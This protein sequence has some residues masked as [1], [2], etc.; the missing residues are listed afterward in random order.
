M[1]V[2][3]GCIYENTTVSSFFCEVREAKDYLINSLNLIFLSN[4]WYCHLKK[5]IRNGLIL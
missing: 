1:E 5:Q 3:Y 4:P 2:S